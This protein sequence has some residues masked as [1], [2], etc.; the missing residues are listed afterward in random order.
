MICV[1]GYYN[2]TNFYAYA[3]LLSFFLI[4]LFEQTSI[5]AVLSTE[6]PTPKNAP[7]PPF[8]QKLLIQFWLRKFS[9]YKEWYMNLKIFCFLSTFK[10]SINYNNFYFSENL[11]VA[12]FDIWRVCDIIENDFGCWQGFWGGFLES[13]WEPE[14]SGVSS[15]HIQSNQ[16]S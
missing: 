7:N 6:F 15:L 1:L 5:F 4:G 9:D 10:T 8:I 3:V 13:F 12:F 11:E 2:S 16:N 14:D